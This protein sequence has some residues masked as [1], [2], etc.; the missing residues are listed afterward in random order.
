MIDG[1]RPAS[2][3]PYPFPLVCVDASPNFTDYSTT[4]ESRKNCEQ[5]ELSLIRAKSSTCQHIDP[6]TTPVPNSQPESWVLKGK[7]CDK[8]ESNDHQLNVIRG[9]ISHME[10]DEERCLM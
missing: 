9:V 5:V 10:W 6:T 1:L 7:K 2:T 3:G 8:N 4:V